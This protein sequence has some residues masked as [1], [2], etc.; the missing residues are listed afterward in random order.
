[1]KKS[2]V[3]GLVMV[4]MVLITTMIPAFAEEGIVGIVSA[5]QKLYGVA[6][7]EQQETESEGINKVE[8]MY[9]KEITKDDIVINADLKGVGEVTV[10][11]EIGQPKQ[12]YHSENFES[13]EIKSGDT[14]TI[15]V[16]GSNLTNDSIKIKASL[17]GSEANGVTI[18]NV[19]GDV[20]TYKILTIKFPENNT[21]ESQ[22]YTVGFSH[23]GH[24]FMCPQKITVNPTRQIIVSKITSVESTISS[25]KSKGGINPLTVKGEN[26]DSN[27]I[28]LEVFE[29][30][31]LL[32]IPYEFKG[33]KE[34]QQAYI[35]FPENNENKD[36]EY[37][38][39]FKIAGS[40]AS[41]KI[42]VQKPG[43][44]EKDLGVK[45]I[46]AVMDETGQVIT[47]IFDKN[48]ISAKK[49]L[50]ELNTEIKLAGNYAATN[51]FESLKPEDKLEIKENQ[52]I[53]NLDVALEYQA[54]AK[55][56]INEGIV[57]DYEGKYSHR[58]E[59]FIKSYAESLKPQFSKIESISN[60]ILTNTGGKVSVTIL[61]ENL[62]EFKKTGGYSQGTIVKVFK[63][64]ST[65]PSEIK[66][67]VT[68]SGNRQTL[69]FE[70]PDNNSDRTETY[71]INISIN[72]GNT[73]VREV[74]YPHYREKPLVIAV[75]PENK[76]DKDITL[77]HMT[78]ASYGTTGSRDNTHTES[79][80]GQESKK[81][82]VNVY[83]T[84]LGEG[85]T[86]VRLV[87][88]YGVE[89]PISNNP[90][91]D[92]TDFPIMVL[93]TTG[94]I[95]GGNFQLFEVILV[96]NVK[97]DVT[98]KYYVAADGVNFDE[99]TTVTAKVLKSGAPNRKLEKRSV[100][101]KYI[102]E[103][104][105]EISEQ[106]VK[107]GYGWFEYGTIKKEIE[108]YEYKGLGK[109]S[110]LIEGWYG[111]S[112]KVVIY[113]YNAKKS[114]ELSSGGSSSSEVEPPSDGTS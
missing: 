53:I 39:N 71:I 9:V 16:Y 44:P 77:S 56:K 76:T 102:D 104:G 14:S 22:V 85:K 24:D 27:G 95:G 63:T 46:D 81:T 4:F 92:S 52:L 87:D 101:S 34:T 64:T 109:N 5:N 49:N 66:V 91:N 25:M 114:E 68:G 99:G 15:R 60:E 80:T 6:D 28:K 35:R 73:Y 72:G 79:P 29:E 111:D 97:Q 75:L 8:S 36:K 84:N 78:I 107:V 32:D 13:Q 98:F 105:N 1:M 26:L 100:T 11:P 23:N 83:G 86:K 93:N 70:L 30:G 55:L 47:V 17:K 59:N 90:G 48:I 110:A 31:T 57:K 50:S 62:K 38:I 20:S 19:E 58:F 43:I 18:S 51:S 12:I 42:I 89:W 106:E 96:N 2:K 103:R 69:E 67:G 65:S 113:V 40:D 10:N 108:G 94:I 33:D 7:L 74:L 45:A 21:G 61:G 112:D 3:I 54:N 41:T 82:W 37:L 88:E